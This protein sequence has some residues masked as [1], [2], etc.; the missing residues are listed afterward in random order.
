[1]GGRG[2]VAETLA[3]MSSH[4]FVLGVFIVGG[5]EGNPDLDTAD[6]SNLGFSW[7]PW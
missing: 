4:R 1:M 7:A 2:A 5:G 6:M 3:D